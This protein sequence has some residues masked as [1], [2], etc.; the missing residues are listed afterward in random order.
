MIEIVIALVIIKINNSKIYK[1]S[2]KK[3]IKNKRDKKI[4]ILLSTLINSKT[5]KVQLY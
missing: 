5:V 4:I 3:S 1:Y 2:K